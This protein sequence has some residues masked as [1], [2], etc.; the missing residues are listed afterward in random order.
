MVMDQTEKTR[1]GFSWLRREGVMAALFLPLLVLMP[2]HAQSQYIPPPAT[3]TYM[4]P[5]AA[6]PAGAEAD[7]P[8]R[9][10]RRAPAPEAV[11]PQSETAHVKTRSER[12][13]ERRAARAA[14]ALERAQLT[15]P[16]EKADAPRDTRPLTLLA[17]DAQSARGL[18]AA[19]IAETVERKGAHL[20]LAP[21]DLSTL[22]EN[23]SADLA[24][25]Q[26]D[27]L[28]E[29]RRSNGAPL[30]KKLVYVAR[31]YHQEVHLITRGS[32]RFFA[33][34]EGGRVATAALGTPEEK[35][36]QRLFQRAGLAVHLLPMDMAEAVRLLARGDIDAALVIG[37]KPM[38]NM[39]SLH[40]SGLHLVAIP[41]K[42][43]LQDDYYPARLTREDYPDLIKGEDFVETIALGTILMARDPSNDP[44]RTKKLAQFVGTF[45]DSFETLRSADHH[46][47]WREVNLAADVPGWRRLASAQKWLDTAPHPRVTY[48]K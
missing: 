29:A 10:A 6:K 5:S 41:Y 22:M 8:V 21:G 7:A 42:G 33:E 36:A 39:R 30:S 26:S 43:A 14:R 46:P 35:T 17:G 31:L 27:A 34:L 32:I 44:E 37:G 3:Q 20:A 45:F 9:R 28:D 25:V 18:A 2:T 13:A 15:K 1:K 47:K 11:A 19:D 23:G 16:K 24:I 4:P 38:A 40:V 48:L 12:R